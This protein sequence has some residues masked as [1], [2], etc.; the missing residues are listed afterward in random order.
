[1]QGMRLYAAPPTPPRH[2]LGSLGLATRP[3][4][5]ALAAAPTPGSETH[6][7]SRAFLAL[8]AALTRGRLPGGRLL[9]AAKIDCRDPECY[10]CARLREPPRWAAGW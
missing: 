3:A 1:M 4:L 9:F 8:A 10:G 5:L 6:R 2:L 7:R